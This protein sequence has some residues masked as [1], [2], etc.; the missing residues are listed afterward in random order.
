MLGNCCT[1]HSGRIGEGSVTQA[2]EGGR[3]R[4]PG[5]VIPLWTIQHLG[6]RVQA[7]KNGEIP[8]LEIAVSRVTVAL[9]PI[10]S[11]FRDFH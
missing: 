3:A 5:R 6:G 2:G 4:N 8:H 9:T 1:G 11:V 7:L 10:L